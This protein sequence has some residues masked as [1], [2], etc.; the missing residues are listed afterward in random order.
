M[1]AVPGYGEVFGATI[2]APIWQE[3]MTAAKGD[4]CEDFPQPKTPFEAQP[5]HGHFE[6]RHG[7]GAQTP[8]R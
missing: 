1:T 7:V 6:T 2:P 4:Y 5:F 8:L 3:F